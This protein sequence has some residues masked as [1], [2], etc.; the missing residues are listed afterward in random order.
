MNT[1]QNL[2]QTQA[3]SLQ[4]GQKIILNTGNVSL[5]SH[6]QCCLKIFDVFFLG[7]FHI[8]FVNHLKREFEIST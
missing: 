5:K 1:G 6:N 8:S 3:K 4:C 2:L 7:F